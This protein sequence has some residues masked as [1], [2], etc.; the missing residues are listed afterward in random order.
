LLRFNY[1][2]LWKTLFNQEANHGIWQTLLISNNND[3]DNK[4]NYAL[5][6]HAITEVQ[7]L[8]TMQEGN[9]HCTL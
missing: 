4:K 9:G 2:L 6:M 5:N 7:S 8:E 1:Q 3:N